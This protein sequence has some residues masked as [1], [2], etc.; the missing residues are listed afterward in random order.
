[1]GRKGCIRRFIYSETAKWIRYR[2]NTSLTEMWVKK[3][4]ERG[5]F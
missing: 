1:M 3:K 4:S 2:E 5:F